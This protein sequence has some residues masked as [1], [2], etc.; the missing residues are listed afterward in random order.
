MNKKTKNVNFIIAEFP[1]VYLTVF[2]LCAWI[3]FATYMYR[4]NPNFFSVTIGIAVL[5]IFRQNRTFF[6][7]DDS[8]FEVKSKY[9]LPILNR[10]TIIKLSEIKDIEIKKDDYHEL[11]T[12]QQFNRLHRRPNMLLITLKDNSIKEYRCVGL[13]K[14]NTILVELITKLK[15]K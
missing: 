6:I 10:S 1:V 15:H 11:T 8:E 12:W 3:A 5:I 14:E 4:L 2:L 9:L 7:L 13:D